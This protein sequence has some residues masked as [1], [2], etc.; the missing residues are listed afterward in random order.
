MSD[1]GKAIL[2]W[3]SRA[4]DRKTARGR[5][6]SARLRRASPIELLCEPEVHELAKDLE[7]RDAE[8]LVRIVTV[9]AEVRENSGAHLAR[10]LGGSEPILSHLRFQRLMRSND[11]ELASGLR[12]AI[13][14]ADHRCNVAALGEDLMFWNER[15]R[16]RWC[17]QYFGA[18]APQSISEEKVE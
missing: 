16:T 17:F 14:M 13:R 5:A 2:S 6:L 15:T 18:D 3:W 12:R 10:V 1:K 11:N 4:L 9:L 7:T 8:R